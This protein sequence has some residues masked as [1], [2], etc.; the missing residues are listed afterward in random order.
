MMV[1]DC[2]ECSMN[3][4]TFKLYIRH[5]L[6]KECKG[7]RLPEDQVSLEPEKKKFKSSEIHPHKNLQNVPDSMHHQKLPDTQKGVVSRGNTDL[8]MIPSSHQIKATTTHTPAHKQVPATTKTT[9]VPCNLCNKLIKPRGMTQHMTLQ[10]K[11][12]YCSILIENVDEHVSQVHE[13]EPCDHCGKKF[14]NEEAVDKHITVAHLLTCTTCDEEF[15]SEEN[16]KAHVVDIHESE[17]C[18]ICQM[19][20]LI[21]DKKMDD[22]KDKVHG[23]K[24]KTIKQFGGMMFMMVSD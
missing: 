17:E 7:K 19:K 18:D 1:A 6:T 14:E 22:H 4:P 5:L 15:Y 23:I 11:C 9:K 3:F 12:L 21:A 13:R 8:V 10:H 2:G 24:N 20:F 16:L